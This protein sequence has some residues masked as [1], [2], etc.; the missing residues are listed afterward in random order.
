MAFC[1]LSHGSAH[2][3][4]GAVARAA[5]RGD[6]FESG[7]YEHGFGAV[8]RLVAKSAG[9][10]AGD[11]IGF[12]EASALAAIQNGGN[13]PWVASS[14]LQSALPAPADRVCQGTLLSR[15]QY[16]KDI[17]EWGYRDPRLEP[18]GAMSARDVHRWTAAA[19]GQK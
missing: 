12:H 4:V 19:N 14:T 3:D 7:F 1:G 15:E 2:Q 11:R 10:P 16:L 17:Q 8:R 18:E 9:K 6:P 5:K 13:N